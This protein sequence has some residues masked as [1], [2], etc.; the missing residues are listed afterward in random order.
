MHIQAHS[1]VR[2]LDHLGTTR[3]GAFGRLVGFPL[4]ARCRL[5]VFLDGFAF[6]N[7]FTCSAVVVSGM[8]RLRSAHQC[9]QQRVIAYQE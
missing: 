6:E 9:E 3:D 8:R 7:V 4:V 2:Q 5:D 1:D